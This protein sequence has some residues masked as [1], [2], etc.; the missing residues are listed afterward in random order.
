MV[1][2]RAENMAHLA[3][4]AAIFSSGKQCVPVT[5][6]F[7]A[8]ATAAEI[9]PR[10]ISV[11][12]E[13]KRVNCCPICWIFVKPSPLWNATY[14]NKLVHFYNKTNSAGLNVTP[15]IRRVIDLLL[16]VAGSSLL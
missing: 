15:N 14:S 13:R 5:A 8:L 16:F 4:P 9:F 7:V 1:S 2:C 6:T 10:K 11:R 12:E 3:S